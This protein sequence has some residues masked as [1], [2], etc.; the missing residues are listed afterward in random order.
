MS[1][2]K[3]CST[4]WQ[5]SQDLPL[6]WWKM[7]TRENKSVLF[8]ITV[9]KWNCRKYSHPFLE[10]KSASVCKRQNLS[11][12]VRCW[13]EII[14]LH[15]LSKQKSDTGKKAFDLFVTKNLANAMIYFLRIVPFL[16]CAASK[17]MMLVAERWT[18]LVAPMFPNAK[19]SFAGGVKEY[20]LVNGRKKYE[21]RMLVMLAFQNRFAHGTIQQVAPPCWQWRPFRHCWRNLWAMAMIFATFGRYSKPQLPG[22]GCFQALPD[23]RASKCTFWGP[24]S[25]SWRNC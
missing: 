11:F 14:F 16:G 3:K 15:N 7:M 2:W 10:F 9:S 25:T 21:L 6:W 19:A 18:K 12:Y 8:A 24:D 22:F 17:V 20:T 5:Y 23:P 4:I 13:G 1:T